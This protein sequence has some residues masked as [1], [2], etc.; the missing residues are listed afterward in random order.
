MNNGTTG[1]GLN[2]RAFIGSL[3]GLGAVGVGLGLAARSGAGPLPGGPQRP[4]RVVVFQASPPD[5]PSMA[6]FR[7]ALRELGWVDGE[8]LSLELVTGSSDNTKWLD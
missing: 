1:S 3:A 8:N 4:V 2:R 7:N 5:P 6:D